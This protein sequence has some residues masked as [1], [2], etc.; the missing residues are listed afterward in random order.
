MEYKT[1][2]K[3]GKNYGFNYF[4]KT[5]SVFFPDGMAPICNKCLVEM[6]KDAGGDTSYEIIDKACQWLD[7]PFKIEMWENL[8]SG[9]GSGGFIEYCKIV[10]EESGYGENIDWKKYNEQMKD[11][12]EKGKL[13]ERM[14]LL[15]AARVNELKKK[16]GFEYLPEDLEYLENLYE[17]IA[18]TQNI[19]GVL[20]EDQARKLC[21]IS[22][23]IETKMR[24]GVD[25]KNELTAYK[26]T[27]AIA[28]FSQQKV[29]EA[30]DFSSVG[31]LF[32]YLE[33]LGWKPHYYRGAQRDIID[34]MMKNI[35][36][37]IRQLYIG[38]SSIP[39]EVERRI[40]GLKVASRL[41]HDDDATVEQVEADIKKEIIDETYDDLV[42]LDF[43]PD[44]GVDA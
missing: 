2:N 31:E 25:F 44:A 7:I 4:V 9:F 26:D 33:K 39:E 18:K 17:G 34:K 29:K 40:E 8:K 11:E 5:K 37:N 6:L 38:E 42:D 3:C 36:G 41:L 12:E 27:M 21:K 20:Q 13:I 43:D 35:Q 32:T 28:G 22:L 14:P 15:S 1:C 30:N 16:W 24:A 19:T 10:N 23:I